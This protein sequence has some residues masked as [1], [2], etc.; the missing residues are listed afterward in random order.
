MLEVDNGVRGSLDHCLAVHRFLAQLPS[1]L[2]IRRR[3][4][5][6]A[7]HVASF[8]V[9]SADPQQLTLLVSVH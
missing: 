9:S 4:R 1:L 5:R 6:A 3:I 2:I 8:G 7:R